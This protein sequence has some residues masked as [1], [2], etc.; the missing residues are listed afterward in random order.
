VAHGSADPRAGAA[1]ADLIGLARARAAARGWP[2]L[3]V[4]AA[5]LGHAPPSAA[6]VLGALAASAP[7]HGSPDGP[8]PDDGARDDG[9]RTRSVVVLPLLLTAAYHSGTDIPGTLRAAQAAYPWL[10]I[11]YGEP[12]GPHPALLRTLDRRLAEAGEDGRADRTAVVLA[13]AGSSQPTANAAVA[14]MAADWQ[15]VSRWRA[16]VPAYASVAAPTPE[17]AVTALL[18]DGA[19]RVVVA[20]YLLAPGLF[21]DRIRAASLAAGATAVAGPLGAAPEVADLLLQRYAE[22]ATTMQARP[23]DSAGA[24]LATRVSAR[25]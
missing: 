17:Q 13:A 4:R 3:D 1:I 16:V 8:A 15:H 2:G 10:A 21:A 9:A 20:T 14:R 12:L 18:R 23:A 7:D 22:A 11:S 24:A 19:P 5:F 25:S 6:Q